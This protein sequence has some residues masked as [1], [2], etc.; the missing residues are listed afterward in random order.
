[1]ID[2]NFKPKY[3]KCDGPEWAQL[4]SAGN[5]MPCIMEYMLS[6]CFL[7]LGEGRTDHQHQTDPD[8]KGQYF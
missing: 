3:D 4:N 5:I 2:L 6:D 7:K 8:V 1:L